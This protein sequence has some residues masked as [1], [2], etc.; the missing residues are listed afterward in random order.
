MD[1]TLFPFEQIRPA[2]NTLFAAGVKYGFNFVM[3]VLILLVGWWLGERMARATRQALRHTHADVTF[4][5]VLSSLVMWAVR[6]VAVVAALGKFGVQTASVLTVLGAAGLAIG[7]ALQGTLQN[8]AAGLMMLLLRPFRVG[9]YIEGTGPATGTVAEISLFNTRLIRGD[10]VS[11]YVPNSQLWTNPVVNYTTTERLDIEVEIG[12]STDAD[13]AVSTI[14][15]L[16]DGDLRIVRAPS[17]APIV[18]VDDFKLDG[19]RLRVSLWTRR[20]NV[21]LMRSDLTS[22]ITPAPESA[23][24]E[25]PSIAGAAIEP[26]G[27]PT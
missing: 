14:R 27:V 2:I 8:I 24:C 6:I 17:L 9:D 3:A 21:D 15:K 18:T 10:G 20:E 4:T 26:V 1:H 7:L 16:I 12:R 11:V 19:A 22:R 23:G 5:P 25:R 13:A